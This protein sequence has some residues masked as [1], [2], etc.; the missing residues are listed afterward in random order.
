MKGVIPV[1]LKKM[2]IEN[3]GNDHWQAI[4]E[5]ADLPKTTM[6]SVREDVEDATI[7]KVMASCAKVLE[8][9]MSDII[10]EFGDYWVNSFA[11]KIYYAYYLG[12]SS[13]KEMILKIDR[14]HNM[15][16]RDIK[17]ARPPR[18]QY[19]EID[20]KTLRV[21]YNSERNLIDLFIGLTKGIGKYFKE[22]LKIKKIDEKNIEIKFE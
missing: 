16:T 22:D 11:P 7:L 9:S 14:I 6:F 21:T 4:L 15:V 3:H 12:V 8:L 17:N 13:A 10:D 20:A 18:F 19:E 1:C 5:D 2:V